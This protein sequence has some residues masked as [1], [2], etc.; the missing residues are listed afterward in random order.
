MNAARP[1]PTARTTGPARRWCVQ[2][3][4][5]TAWSL[6]ALHVGP[7]PAWHTIGTGAAAKAAR[8]CAPPRVGAALAVV[9][10]TESAAEVLADAYMAW[11]VATHGY[12]DPSNVRIRPAPDGAPV[13]VRLTNEPPGFVVENPAPPPSDLF[14]TP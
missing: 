2:V 14:A 4:T 10:A 8:R 1:T 9:A 11:H 12:G 13:T 6:L 7:S 5:G 3:F